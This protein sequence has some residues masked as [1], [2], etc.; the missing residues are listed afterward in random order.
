MNHFVNPYS[1]A[2]TAETRI[3]RALLEINHRVLLAAG[4]AERSELRAIAESL[5]GELVK[6]VQA[7]AIPT[8]SD[9]Q[10]AQTAQTPMLPASVRY[11]G[12]S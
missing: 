7:I 5:R 1:E 10:R 2:E 4:E 3:Y 8:E 11:S 6:L 9:V 12:V